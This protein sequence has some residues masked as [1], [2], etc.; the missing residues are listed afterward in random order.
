VLERLQP[1]PPADVGRNG[2]SAPAIAADDGMLEWESHSLKVSGRSGGQDD[3]DE[4]RQKLR[5]TN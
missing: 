2:S 3:A 5:V 1:L 4:A